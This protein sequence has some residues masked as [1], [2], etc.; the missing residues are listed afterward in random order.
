MILA[1]LLL[2]QLV[3][4]HRAPPALPPGFPRV[5][6]RAAFA[7]VSQL[8]QNPLVDQ[9][10]QPLTIEACQELIDAAPTNSVLWKNDK[11]YSVQT[12]RPTLPLC[13][14]ETRL[15]YQGRP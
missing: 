13:Q 4:T 1:L 9:A 10:A 15:C 6:Y 12:W 2:S 14:P 3:Q 11:C 8:P 7:D 5:E